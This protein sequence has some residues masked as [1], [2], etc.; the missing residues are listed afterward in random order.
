M[1]PGGGIPGLSSAGC[2][3]SVSLRLGTDGHWRAVR[4]RRLKAPAAIGDEDVE[5]ENEPDVPHSGVHDREDPKSP[6]RLQ[7]MSASSRESPRSRTIHSTMARAAIRAPSMRSGAIPIVACAVPETETETEKELRPRRVESL[8]RRPHRSGGETEALPAWGHSTAVTHTS[9][10]PCAAFGSPHENLAPSLHTGRRSTEPK[11]RCRVV[12]VAAS[13]MG[14]KRT[15]A[16]L[17]GG[18]ISHRS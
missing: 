5:W 9:P 13:A 16:L 7:S 15:A 4:T 2:G 14:G 12:S 11:V 1:R 6:A 17:Q 18:I 3:A 10:S 8:A